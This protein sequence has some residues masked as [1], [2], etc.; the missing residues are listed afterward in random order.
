[1]TA[2]ITAERATVTPIRPGLESVLASARAEVV[3]FSSLSPASVPFRR[4]DEGAL[5]PGVRYRAIFPDSVRRQPAMSR[6]LTGLAVAGVD[7]RTVDEVPMDVLVVDRRV[8][9][10][11]A[12]GPAR[13]AVVQL[14]SMVT[15]AT[16]LF[17][18]VWPGAT[19]LPTGT[20]LR[21]AERADQLSERDRQ[22]IT[23]LALGATDEAAARQIDC[24]VRTVRRV[25]AR[26]MDQLGAESRFQAGAKAADR[27]WL[28]Q[29]C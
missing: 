11:P 18:R 20:E 29:A 19:A 25:I 23:L 21:P 8:A 24:S 22:L 17:E 15:V 1:M 12:E 27:G 5:R 4:F 6:Y 14:P 3:L 9:V 13:I 16:E 10:L 7:V 26:L 2:E 28:I